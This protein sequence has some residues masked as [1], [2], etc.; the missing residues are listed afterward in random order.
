MNR[1]VLFIDTTTPRPYNLNTFLTEG[2]GGTESTVV[3]VAEALSKIESLNVVVEEPQKIG[4]TESKV[5][6]TTLGSTA[7][8]DYVV[9]LRNPFELV[10]A[11]YRFPKAK[12]YL[13][14]HDVPTPGLNHAKEILKASQGVLCVSDWHRVQ[15][16]ET[17]KAAGYKGEYPVITVYNPIEDDLKPDNTPYDKNK[18]LFLSSPHKGLE[19]AL[20]LFQNLRN[21]NPDFKLHVANPG[22][23]TY[24]SHW[25]ENV[26]ALGPIPYREVVRELRSSLCLFFP[27]Y[28]FPETFGRVIAE[29]NAVGTPVL[30]HGLAATWEVC[31]RPDQEI[32]ECR[33]PKTVIDRVLLWH[34]G[35]RPSVR[36]KKEFRLSNVVST[37]LRKVFK[38]SG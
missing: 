38:H 4:T 12:I 20:E 5:T 33:D 35:D 17:L 34:K 9:V 11:R 25:Q 37:W 29:S 36:V 31:D 22:Y 19:W 3:R 21:F 2:M 15:T 18:L 6:Y 26:T 13:W 16:I 28:V 8:A 27:N 30:T 7:H 14:S 24:K 1:T 32:V 10:S 23:L